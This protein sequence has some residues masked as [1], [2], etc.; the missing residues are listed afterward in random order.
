MFKEA[1]ICGLG[2][3]LDLSGS[4]YHHSQSAGIYVPDG[5]ACDWIAV[6]ELLTDSIRSEH[7]KILEDA[8]KQLFGPVARSAARGCL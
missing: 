2:M 7:P 8:A 5:I 1:M 4:G 6:G 3:V